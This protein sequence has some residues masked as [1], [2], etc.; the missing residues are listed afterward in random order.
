MDKLFTK[1]FTLVM[2][3][4]CCVILTSCGNDNGANISDYD[5]TIVFYHTQ[6]DSLQKKTAIAIENFEKKYPGWKVYQTQVG[7]YDDVKSKIVSDLQGGLQ[8]DLA[9]CYSD[10]VAQYIQTEKVVDLSKL[11]DMGEQTVKTKGE[12]GEYTVENTVRIG[13][14]AEEKADIVEG[15]FKEGY[16]TNYGDYNKYGYTSSSIFSL[17]FVKST[18]LLYYNKTA[19][20]ACGLTPANTWEELWEQCAVLKKK[21]PTC[22]PLGYD[23]EANWFITMC[24]Q[25]GWGYTSA[26]ASNHYLFNN[27]NTKAWLE[28][29]AEYYDKGYIAT[30]EEY[31]SYTSNLFTKGEKDGGCIYCVGSSGG[32]SHQASTLFTWGIAPIPGS[33]QA[34]G[35]INKAAISQGPKLCMFYNDRAKDKDEKAMMTFLFVKE[36]LEPTFQAAFSIESGYNPSRVST[37]EVEKY[38]EHLEEDSITAVAAK[39]ATTMTND[40]FTSPAFVGS[41]TARTQVGNILVY[42]LTGQKSAEKA[43]KDGYT[44]CG[45]K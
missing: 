34:D 32:A 9:Y 11:I 35:S 17:P 28:S 12:D 41:S 27:A 43:L 31:G 25:N 24:E 38:V 20:D 39:V 19:L 3:A 22:T 37:Y 1:V 29:L 15:Y 13:F 18:E 5:H 42:T 7:G 36:L 6:G 40:F 23:S 2:A 8:P 30:Q 4:L 21:Y 44:N 16:A 45:G 26:D 10:H 14:T 33:K